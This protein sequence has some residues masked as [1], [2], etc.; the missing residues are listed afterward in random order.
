[1]EDINDL[2]KRAVKRNSKRGDTVETL[3]KSYK[4]AWKPSG[5]NAGSSTPF[6]KR[7]RFEL[8]PSSEQTLDPMAQELKKHMGDD[9]ALLDFI[10]EF[11][12]KEKMEA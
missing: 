3:T 2:G 9:N 4:P 8:S 5:R 12:A 7:S 6:R 11:M 10:K 1:M